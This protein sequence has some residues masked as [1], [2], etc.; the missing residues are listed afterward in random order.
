[1]VKMEICSDSEDQQI[2]KLNESS[3]I[4]YRIR[5]VGRGARLGFGKFKSKK[6]NFDG[7]VGAKDFRPANNE[8]S[9][10]TNGSFE[11]PAH[12]HRGAFLA[13]SSLIS[14]SLLIKKEGDAGLAP[15]DPTAP[16]E[17]GRSQALSKGA[18]ATTARSEEVFREGHPQ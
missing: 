16:S 17:L 6:L 13:P 4:A 9:S 10:A 18:K 15:T 5:K 12:D 1:M 3:L 14:E 7:N 11:P 2:S 8:A